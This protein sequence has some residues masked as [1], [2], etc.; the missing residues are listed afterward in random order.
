MLRLRRDK[1][2]SAQVD[3]GE[4]D[5]RT[6]RRLSAAGGAWE[7]QARRRQKRCSRAVSGALKGIFQDANI[8]GRRDAGDLTKVRTTSF[9][10]SAS[11]VDATPSLSACSISSAYSP[12]AINSCA[13]EHSSQTL[14]R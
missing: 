1:G 4:G 2:R 10:I 8:E 3:D 12:G 13:P 9:S 11:V 14:L 7:R 5:W 6:R